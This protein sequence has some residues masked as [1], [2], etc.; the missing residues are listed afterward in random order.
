[1]GMKSYDESPSLA[2]PNG[3]EWLNRLSSSGL[4][5]NLFSAVQL[6]DLNLVGSHSML[7]ALTMT[8]SAMGS[9]NI[10]L[11]RPLASAVA[12]SKLIELS[13]QVYDQGGTGHSNNDLFHELLQ[14]LGVI[15]LLL[16]PNSSVGADYGPISPLIDLLVGLPVKYFIDVPCMD[17]IFPVL[18]ALILHDNLA[19]ASINRQLHMSYITTY[20]KALQSGLG[21]TR[22]NEISRRL[23]ISVWNIVSSTLKISDEVG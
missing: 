10:G 2:N 13:L 23:P 22:V 21:S 11:L 14:L 5:V 6:A 9:A 3:N 12:I 19:V 8:L 15:L 16:Q 7:L 4:A 1:M 20:L 17:V 18:I